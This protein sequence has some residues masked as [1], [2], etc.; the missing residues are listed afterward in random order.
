MKKTICLILASCFYLT[1]FSQPL[2]TLDSLRHPNCNDLKGYAYFTLHFYPSTPGPILVKGYLIPGMEYE[3]FDAIATVYDNGNDFI[4]PYVY[5]V[6]AE[7][8]LTLYFVSPS[9]NKIDTANFHFNNHL[10]TFDALI[11]NVGN[12]LENHQISLTASGGTPPYDISFSNN[13]WQTSQTIGTFSPVH[14]D[15]ATHITLNVPF[16]HYQFKLVDKYCTVFSPNPNAGFDVWGVGK[17]LPNSYMTICPEILGDTITLN[18]LNYTREIY[19]VSGAISTLWTDTISVEVNFDDGTSQTYVNTVQNWLTPFNISHTFA[20]GNIYTVIYNVK[21]THASQ[22]SSWYTGTTMEYVNTGTL[23]VESNSINEK[24]SIYPNPVNDILY[25][26]K[27]N[28]DDK[29][30]EIEISD[31]LGNKLICYLLTG[32][33]SSIDLSNLSKGIYLIKIIN[34]NEIAIIKR[35]V[36]Q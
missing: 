32:N 30:V 19:V 33:S 4:E 17:T 36:K 28:N 35:I 11:C 18:S 13:N 23:S 29:N 26:S 15:S 8:D 9:A 27:Q 21:N 22:T 6:Q 12:C 20:Q 16:G 2:F 14:L 34:E 1:T 31:I 24:Y 7:G 5:S 10:I 25:V 3:T